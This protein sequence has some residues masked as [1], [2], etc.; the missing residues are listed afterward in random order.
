MKPKIELAR[1]TTPDG[2][3]LTLLEHANDYYIEIDGET[4]MTTRG[5]GSERA[6]AEL[7]IGALV[8]IKIPRVLIGGLGLS[9]TLGAALD[10]LPRNGSVVVAELLEAVVDWNQK[11][12]FESEKDRLADPRVTVKQRDVVDVLRDASDE[13]DAIM[14]DVDNGP[15]S[16][17]LESNH[18]LYNTGGLDR[19][20]RALRPEGILAIWSAGESTAFKRTMSKAGFETETTTVRSRGRK[21]EKHTIYIGRMLSGKK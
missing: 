1:T 10:A 7:A 13:F 11:F 9:F 8:N 6:L 15:D 3:L 20:K 4:L 21:G 14:L 17:C 2:A 5:Y 19:I 12:S 18:R 16:F